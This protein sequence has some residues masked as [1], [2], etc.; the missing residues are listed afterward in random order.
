MKTITILGYVF[1]LIKEDTKRA[2]NVLA[3]ASIDEGACLWSVYGRNSEAKSDAMDECV[4][5]ELNLNGTNGHIASHNTFQFTYAFTF[6]YKGKNYT[7]LITRDNK[8]L[9]ATR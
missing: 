9:T 4:N 2:S 3:C 6:D 8:Y 7:A 1:S 5:M